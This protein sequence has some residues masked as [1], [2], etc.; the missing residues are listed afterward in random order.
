[1]VLAPEEGI[2]LRPLVS[3]RQLRFLR[4]CNSRQL[5]AA[6]AV[7]LGGTSSCLSLKHL[8]IDGNMLTCSQLPLVLSWFELGAMNI[9]DLCYNNL[10]HLPKVSSAPSY[11]PGLTCAQCVIYSLLHRCSA[12]P[13]GGNE[14][15]WAGLKY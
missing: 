1:M 6:M 8:C 5:S 10:S 11:T 4:L 13:K 2:Q 9:L 7:G 12:G 3:L 14:V 15:L